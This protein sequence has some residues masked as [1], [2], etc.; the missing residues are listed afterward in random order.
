[1]HDLTDRLDA[2]CTCDLDPL[3]WRSEGIVDVDIPAEVLQEISAARRECGIFE[4]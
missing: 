4:P 3:G 2:D 1:M